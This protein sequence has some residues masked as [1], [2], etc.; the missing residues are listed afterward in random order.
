MGVTFAVSTLSPTFVTAG[1]FLEKANLSNTGT[2]CY[3]DVFLP[4]N[5]RQCLSS[6]WETYCPN[7]RRPWWSCGQRTRT[8]SNYGIIPYGLVLCT[9]YVSLYSCIEIVT[10]IRQGLNGAF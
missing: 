10:W 3:V 9:I 5:N 4:P 1:L 6:E 8:M 2:L 7:S